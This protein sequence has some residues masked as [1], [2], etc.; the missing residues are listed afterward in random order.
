MI[1]FR[2]CFIRIR[3]GFYIDTLCWSYIVNPIIYTNE[4]LRMQL[5]LHLKMYLKIIIL[6]PFFIEMLQYDC[7]WSGYMII[8]EMFYIPI[9][10]K[11]ELARASMTTS[12]VKKLMA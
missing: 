10:L 8:K 1:S 2:I 12:D 4:A 11:P 6:L 3:V 5:H 7:L 9:K